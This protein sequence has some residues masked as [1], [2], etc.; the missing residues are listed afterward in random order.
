V[1]ATTVII[2]S[3]YFVKDVGQMTWFLLINASWNTRNNI[4]WETHQTKTGN[5]LHS[6]LPDMKTMNAK[7]KH[8]F[9]IVVLKMIDEILDNTESEGRSSTGLAET[10]NICDEFSESR[11]ESSLL[12]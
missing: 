7:L 4:L 5:F 1:K 8:I 11:R 2:N 10:F 12:F 3:G 6:L 9:K